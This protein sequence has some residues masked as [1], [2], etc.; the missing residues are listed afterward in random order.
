MVMNT[1]NNLNLNTPAP[2]IRQELQ[3]IEE[4]RGRVKFWALAVLVLALGAI[5][6]YTYPQWQA[7]SPLEGQIR[8]LQDLSGGL[9]QRLASAEQNLQTWNDDRERLAGKI[10]ELEK[11]M[12]SS[13]A[14]ARKQTQELAAGVSQRID[15]EIGKR[16]EPVT[17]RMAELENA[18][19]A[20]GVRIARVQDEIS[21][22][23]RDTLQQ[24]AALRN[25]TSNQIADVNQQV[26]R[27]RRE[28]ERL[29]H[30]QDRERVTFE[31][32]KNRAS[33]LAPGISLTIN[34]TDV[35]HQSVDGWISLVPDGRTLW[36]SRQKIQEPLLF[37]TQQD[38]R[39][40]ELVLT[41]VADNG[42]LGYL[43]VPRKGNSRTESE[44]IG[45]GGPTTP[46]R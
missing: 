42:A 27:D 19:R 1:P 21:G 3:V 14:V 36:V 9:G 37:Y 7:H 30:I 15:Q 17:A 45:S 24:I 32:S 20:D 46:E 16:L 13:A 6:W 44:V 8:S 4:E 43:I 26:D 12:R 2:E 25:G 41:R 10:D 33:E 23:R 35:A 22:L 38:D 11:K 28:L 34:H 5:G 39:V 29:A 40:H 18:Q 31:A